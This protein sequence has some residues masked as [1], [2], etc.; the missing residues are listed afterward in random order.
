LEL[1]IGSLALAARIVVRI[2]LIILV[3]RIITKQIKVV[4]ITMPKS[5]CDGSIAIADSLSDGGFYPGYLIVRAHASDETPL[6]LCLFVTCL[7]L[8]DAS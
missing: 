8:S 4:P 7:L 2:A 6:F 3:F 1:G 5:L